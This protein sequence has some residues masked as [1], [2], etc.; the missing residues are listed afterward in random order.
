MQPIKVS[1]MTGKLKGLSGINF[2]PLDNE[3]CMSMAGKEGTVCGHCYSRKMLKTFR[4]NAEPAFAKNSRELSIL[5]NEEDLPSFIQGSFVRFLAHGELHNATQAQNFIRIAKK[6]PRSSFALWTKRPFLVQEAADAE[7][8]IPHNLVLIQSI[9]L[10]DSE[11]VFQHPLFDGVFRVFNPDKSPEP[12]GDMWECNGK[13]C[14]SCL[15]CYSKIRVQQ[16]PHII[17]KLRK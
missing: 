4:K 14:A 10:L 2:S 7:G 12:R 6:S 15:H 9:S 16:R 1:T 11:Q 5:R 8:G 17:E 3:F 13:N